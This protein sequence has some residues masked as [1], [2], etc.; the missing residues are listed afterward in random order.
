MVEELFDLVDEYNRPLNVTKP[1]S[2]VHRDGDWHRVA[3]IYVI[4]NAGEFLV[5]LRSPFKDRN[6]NRWTATF[7]GHAVSGD[8]VETTAE[9]E[10][11]EELG[12]HVITEQLKAITV[13]KQITADGRNKEFRYLYLFPFNGSLSDLKFQDAEVVKVKWMSLQAIQKAMRDHPHN[14]S[15]DTDRLKL[16]YNFY[17]HHT[18][19]AEI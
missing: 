13:L 2:A 12:L 7:G 18:S 8:S 15:G 4:N 10:L 14:W 16:I 3:H 5:N 6:P 11:Q 17:Q 1:R 19:H 9:K